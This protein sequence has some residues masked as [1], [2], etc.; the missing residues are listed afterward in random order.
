MTILFTA[1]Y[2]QGK[3]GSLSGTLETCCQ[4]VGSA[5]LLSS[6]I[7]GCNSAHA[8]ELYVCDG[9][10]V[11][12][13]KPCTFWATF[14]GSGNMQTWGEQHGQFYLCTAF[15]FLHTPLCPPSRQQRMGTFE[16]GKNTEVAKDG[17]GGVVSEGHGL[18]TIPRKVS[19]ALF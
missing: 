10:P 4:M 1:A 5:V 3:E 11:V 14:Q 12:A 13:Q 19:S 17:W 9:E 18:G 2:G 8:F 15:Y 7:P 6:S 16:P